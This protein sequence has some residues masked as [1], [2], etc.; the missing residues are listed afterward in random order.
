V[1]FNFSCGSLCGIFFVLFGHRPKRKSHAASDEFFSAVKREDVK[2][3]ETLC[4]FS[5]AE[6][7]GSNSDDQRVAGACKLIF[8]LTDFE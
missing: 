8:H 4:L 6:P 1:K 5:V 2:K 7:Q 3:T